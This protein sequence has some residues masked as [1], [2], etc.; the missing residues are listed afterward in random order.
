MR[1]IRDTHMKKT[2]DLEVI[3][4]GG[5]VPGKIVYNTDGRVTLVFARPEGSEIMTMLVVDGDEPDSQVEY[6][7]DFN[8]QARERLARFLA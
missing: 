1:D 4:E 8:G 3:G 6:R 5:S 2:H 7:I